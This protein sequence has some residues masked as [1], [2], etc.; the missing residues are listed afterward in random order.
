MPNYRRWR[1]PGGTVFLTVVTHERLLLFADPENVVRLRQAL[2]T[3]MREM[4][5]EIEGAVVLPDHCHFL[6]TLLAG[7]DPYSKRMGRVWC[8]KWTRAACRKVGIAHPTLFRRRLGVD[9]LENRL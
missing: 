4:P 9:V 1:V 7:D 2:R 3:V 8:A 6:W 5:F